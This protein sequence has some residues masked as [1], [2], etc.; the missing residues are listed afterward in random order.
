MLSTRR[1]PAVSV[2]P[3]GD[4]VGVWGAHGSAEGFFRREST[5]D[6]YDREV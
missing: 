3:D 5:V 6:Y 4:K 1:E 2:Y